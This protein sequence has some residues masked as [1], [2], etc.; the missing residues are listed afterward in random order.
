MA[1]PSLPEWYG[2]NPVLE[3]QGGGQR[4][5]IGPIR[6]ALASFGKALAEELAGEDRYT[7]RLAKLDVR[8]QI[9]AFVL[10]IAGATMLTGI[11]PLGVLFTSLIAVALLSGVDMSRLVRIWA[12]VALFNI[13]IIMPATTNLITPG[14]TV[15]VLW[16]PGWAHIGH[17]VMP[18]EIAI[19]LPGLMIAARFILRTL[20]CA[21]LTVM[22]VSTTEHALLLNG[23]RSLGMPK[24][25]GMILAM[26]HRYLV[27]M[28]RSAEEIHLSKLSRTIRYASTRD[29]RRWAAAGI[30]I[31]F[32]RTHRLVQEVDHAMVSRGYD[33]DL[34]VKET[35]RPNIV[36]YLSVGS[37]LAFMIILILADKLI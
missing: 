22:L 29:E 24:V 37:A 17:L 9:L 33:G 7:S 6:R 23:L 10:L 4:R 30:G 8:A 21:T 27:L 11:L 15:L 13:A 19:T 31:L 20:N 16:N 26:M 36:D 35:T 12:G 2:N 28:L 5:F 14:T 32:R 3:E 1:S 18:N 25:F 34:R